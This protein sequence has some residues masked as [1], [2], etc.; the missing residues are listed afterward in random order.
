MCD[1]FQSNNS[2]TTFKILLNLIFSVYLSV[3]DN[4]HC[5]ISQNTLADLK[6]SKVKYN[7]HNELCTG[8]LFNA[9]T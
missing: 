2:L 4:E 5:L 8:R 6:E 9:V 1:T 3:L 7:L